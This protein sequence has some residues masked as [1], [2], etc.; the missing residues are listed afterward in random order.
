MPF[1]VARHQKSGAGQGPRK[2]PVVLWETFFYHKYLLQRRVAIFVI[3]EMLNYSKMPKLTNVFPPLIRIPRNLHRFLPRPSTST[4]Q[5]RTTEKITGKIW[6][7]TNI[8]ARTVSWNAI[9]L[10]DKAGR[11]QKISHSTL[12]LWSNL[13]ESDEP[14]SRRTLSESHQTMQAVHLSVNI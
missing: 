6:L 13:C 2:K 1:L 7:R 10:G 8:T 3:C 9:N 11:G 12:L 5:Y 4:S 14:E